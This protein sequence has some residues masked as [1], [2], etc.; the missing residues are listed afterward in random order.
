[1]NKQTIASILLVTALLTACSGKVETK[2][3]NGKTNER[4]TLVKGPD[5]EKVKNGVF[6]RFD[7]KGTKRDSSNWEMGKQV[8]VQIQW[9]A[10]GTMES[11]CGWA[12]NKRDGKCMEYSGKGAIKKLTTY[13]LDIKNGPEIDYAPNG[14]KLEEVIWKMGKKDSTYQR[15]NE[16]G[17][18]LQI[19]HFKDGKNDGPEKIWCE[20]EERKDVVKEDRTWVNGM[21]QGLETYYLCID[22]KISSILHWKDDKMDGDYTYWEEGKKVVEKYKDGK[23][24]GNCPKLPQPP[25]QAK[26]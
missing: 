4:Y 24:V 20:E 15:W 13:K 16:K 12:E 10:N 26:K 2:H 3:E 21:R 14:Q 19:A 5:G 9:D 6:E 1:M 8:G 11:Q 22:G 25:P 17:R 7:N 23:C 18:P